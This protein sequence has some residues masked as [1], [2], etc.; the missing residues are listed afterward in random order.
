MLVTR[1]LF[2]EETR[3]GY[4]RISGFLPVQGGLYERFEETAYNTAFDLEMVKEMLLGAGFCGVRFARGEDLST[5]AA[6]P[7]AEPRIYI[8]AEK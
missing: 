2:D 3:R 5:P 6:D 4:T 7:E 1:S 8:V